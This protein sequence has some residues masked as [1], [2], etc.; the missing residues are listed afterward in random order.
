M[1]FFILHYL[2]ISILN[3]F[4]LL[5]PAPYPSICVIA[6]PSII[7]SLPP[8]SATLPP[9]N[10]LIL[11]ST[12]MQQLCIILSLQVSKGRDKS[13]VLLSVSSAVLYVPIDPF[14]P[15]HLSL[16]SQGVVFRR[17]QTNSCSLSKPSGREFLLLSQVSL[18]LRLS[19]FAV[20]NYTFPCP[21]TPSQKVRGRERES[22]V[23]G[24]SAHRK[25]ILCQ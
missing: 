5:L 14:T 20:Q 12:T 11:S 13:L 1:F 17:R 19:I 16:V 9:T 24:A 4:L 7:H 3:H 25:N 10:F 15:L 22:G 21:I 2:L 23:G 18:D 6:P 8:P